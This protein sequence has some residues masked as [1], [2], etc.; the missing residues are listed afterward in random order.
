MIVDVVR[1]SIAAQ[2]WSEIICG[3]LFDVFVYTGEA[4]RSLSNGLEQKTR[5]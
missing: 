5:E 1:F 2:F 3:M 4:G